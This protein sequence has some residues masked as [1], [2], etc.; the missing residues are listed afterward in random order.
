[1]KNDVPFL[2]ADHLPTLF[3]AF[4]CF[5]ASFMVRFVWNLDGNYIAGDVVFFSPAQNAG[6]AASPSPGASLLRQVF[7]HATIATNETTIYD[8]NATRNA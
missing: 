6:M 5:D 1:M 4:L 3:I 8:V 2:K 7:N